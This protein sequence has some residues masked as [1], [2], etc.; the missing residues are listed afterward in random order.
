MPASKESN[1][2]GFSIVELVFL[3]AFV[4]IIAGT[5]FV[6]LN[7][8]ARA[9]ESK[10]TQQLANIQNIIS[11]VREYVRENNGQYPNGISPG[12]SITQIGSASLGCD[13]S[14]AQ[15]SASACVNL[16]GAV[17]K[18]VQS[19]PVADSKNQAETGYYIALDKDGNLRVGLCNSEIIQVEGLF[20]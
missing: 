3:I 6:I 12:M 5:V 17:A 14:C 20:D 2:T 16:N 4:S 15:A 8:V 1:H 19:V 13:L 11:A 18:Y 10:K 9:S 7:P